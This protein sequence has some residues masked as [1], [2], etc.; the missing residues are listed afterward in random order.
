M[1]RLLR[2]CSRIRPVGGA[3]VLRPGV[4]GRSG[5]W[6]CWSGNSAYQNATALANP[7][8][9]SQAMA[10]KLKDAGFDVISAYKDL[11]NLRFKRAIRQFEDAADDADI[12]VVF[13]AGH[14][15]EIRGVNYLIPVDATLASDR[16]ADDEAITLDRLL[17]SVEGEPND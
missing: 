16:D 5:A 11:G 9:D 14:G 7:S 2:R 17:Q 12:V 4:G 8:N 1:N 13:Y 3:G 15:I 6:R 10:G